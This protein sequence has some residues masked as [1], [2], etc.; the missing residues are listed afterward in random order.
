MFEIARINVERFCNLA[1]RKYC[2]KTWLI[3]EAE[4]LLKPEH[5][6]VN[7]QNISAFRLAKSCIVKS[8]LSFEDVFSF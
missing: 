5:T 7:D 2:S 1:I 6:D 3:F 4:L 8:S